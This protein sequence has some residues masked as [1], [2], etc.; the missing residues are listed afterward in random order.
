LVV[1]EVHYIRKANLLE[2]AFHFHSC[3][4]IMRFRCNWAKEKGDE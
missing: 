2:D 4:F 1:E 3:L